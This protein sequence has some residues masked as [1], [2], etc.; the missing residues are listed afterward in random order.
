MIKNRKKVLQLIFIILATIIISILSSKAVM[1]MFIQIDKEQPV[2]PYLP[3]ITYNEDRLVNLGARYG[4]L[5]S[6]PYMYCVNN[7]WDFDA[8]G[9]YLPLETQPL[10]STLSYMIHERYPSR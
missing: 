8:T 5:Y 7:G 10:S 4:S 3:T 1:A 9:N 6:S 2:N